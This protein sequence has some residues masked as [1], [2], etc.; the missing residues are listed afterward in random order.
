[1]I[2]VFDWP[3]CSPHLSSVEN[4]WP[5]LEEESNSGCQRFLEPDGF[6]SNCW[7]HLVFV[8]T[9]CL[10]ATAR[11][12]IIRQQRVSEATSQI[13]KLILLVLLLQPCW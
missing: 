6:N 3:A 12:K 5:L 2:F 10:A 7:F 8:F 11:G 4:V 13:H 9:W 1:M